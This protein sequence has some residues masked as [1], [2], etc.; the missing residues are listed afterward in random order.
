MEAVRSSG[1]LL[2]GYS[3][4][5]HDILSQ[6]STAAIFAVPRIQNLRQN[7]G[8][9]LVRRNLQELSGL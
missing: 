1:T 6:K 2:T 4:R 7:N 9:T 8:F 3:A 5:S